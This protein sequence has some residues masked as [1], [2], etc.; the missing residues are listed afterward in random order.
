MF[1]EQVDNS[2]E[3][4]PVVDLV[5]DSQGCQGVRVEDVHD[6]RVLHVLFVKF[7]QYVA[8]TLPTDPFLWVLELI[9]QWL[10]DQ[11]LGFLVILTIPSVEKAVLQY[12]SEADEAGVSDLVVLNIE[13]HLLD[14]ANHS[15]HCFP[16]RWLR[17]FAKLNEVGLE[18]GGHVA[19]QVGM[20]LQSNMVLLDPLLLLGND[21]SC[22][23]CQGLDEDR[24][25]LLG[26][27]ILINHLQAA[28]VAR[29][30]RALVIDSCQVIVEL[31]FDI[32][33]LGYLL[34]PCVTLFVAEAHRLLRLP[35]LGRILRNGSNSS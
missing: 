6:V 20:R 26:V 28:L 27:T 17:V 14:G 4:L 10:E 32:V 35:D 25:S 19:K 24:G 30:V 2:H 29:V 21:D 9:E 15:L 18:L 22:L 23:V 5:L 16:H 3:E 31:N 7:A 13:E 33:Q 34:W 12:L 8:C 1:V 11:I